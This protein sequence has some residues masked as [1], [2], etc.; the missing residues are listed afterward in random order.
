MEEAARESGIPD[1]PLWYWLTDKRTPRIVLRLPP[2][3]REELLALLK[4]AREEY[5]E[6]GNPQ[7]KRPHP[8]ETVITALRML[9]E[10]KS[11]YEVAKAL[12]IS[13]H[14]VWRWVTVALPPSVRGDREA[15]ELRER[16]F[17]ALFPR[18]LK[19]KKR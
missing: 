3:E 15:S 6:R 12:R 19:R 8:R 10:G 2:P 11:T 18:R 1:S 17:R 9:A 5:S 13:T 16:A 14:L 7:R 4:R